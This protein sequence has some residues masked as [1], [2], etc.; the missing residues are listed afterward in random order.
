MF[1]VTVTKFLHPFIVTWP[2]A[3]VVLCAIDLR[4]VNA[5]FPIK[6]IHVAMLTALA[7]LM[8]TVPGIPDD[9][10]CAFFLNHHQRLMMC[11]MQM[12]KKTKP[13]FP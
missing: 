13:I 2:C 1:F 11:P 6:E 10:L 4:G 9:H 3:V 7:D 12:A 8:A 5:T